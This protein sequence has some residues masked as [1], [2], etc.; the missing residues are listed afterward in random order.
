MKNLFQMTEAEI[1]SLPGYVANTLAN[2]AKEKGITLPILS[3]V[4]H[5]RHIK[6]PKC[7]YPNE[8]VNIACYHCG[9]SI[10]KLFRK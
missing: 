4:K 9:Q 2:V 10:A 8:P 5:T 1:M 3:R 7:G 6:C